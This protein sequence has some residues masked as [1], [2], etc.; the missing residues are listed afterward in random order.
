MVQTKCFLTCCC[1]LNKKLLD[2]DG[3]DKQWEQGVQSIWSTT[4]DNDDGNN[5]DML[6]DNDAVNE[7]D[8]PSIVPDAILRLQNPAFERQ[9]GVS[10]EQLELDHNRQSQQTPVLS[11]VD[12]PTTVATTT[13]DDIVEVRRLSLTEF[14][15][16]L[17]SSSL[18]YC[19]R[20]KWGSVATAIY[21]E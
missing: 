11:I 3:L 19:T 13:G 6:L 12:E 1:A 15:R 4:Y 9:Y 2:I 14:R 5:G 18:F 17:A 16:W 21:C 8:V 10:N 7:V 20:K